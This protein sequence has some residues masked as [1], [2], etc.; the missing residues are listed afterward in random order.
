MFKDG[1]AAIDEYIVEM[2]DPVT[3]DWVE[4]ARSKVPSATVTGLTEGEHYQVG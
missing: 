3:K 2:K 1:G 4:C